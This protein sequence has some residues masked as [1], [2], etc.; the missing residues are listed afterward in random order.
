MWAPVGQS[1]PA[2]NAENTSEKGNLY[3]T[4]AEAVLDGL[5]AGTSYKVKVRARYQDDSGP[6][7]DEVTKE[8]QA[9]A[10]SVGTR[11]DTLGTVS[12]LSADPRAFLV[13][14]TWTAIKNNA[15][16]EYEVPRGSS[17]DELAVIGTATTAVYADGPVEA[18]T[19]YY[20][21]VRARSATGFGPTSDAL[22]VTTT[23]ATV[24][25]EEDEEPL[26]A[27]TQQSSYTLVSNLH[28]STSGSNKTVRNVNATH[29]VRVEQPF[30]TGNHPDGYTITEI[31]AFVKSITGSDIG[32]S[33]HIH[34]DNGKNVSTFDSGSS[35]R[36]HSFTEHTG[37]A[38]DSTVRFTSTD[39]VTLSPNT[40]YWLVFAMSA[41]DITSKYELAAAARGSLEITPCGEPGWSIYAEALDS[42]YEI[43]TTNKTDRGN[44]SF[45]PTLVAVIGNQ[46][47]DASESELDCISIPM[48]QTARG[49]L[50]VD[51]D[52]DLFVVE[53]EAGVD[54]Q[55]DMFTGIDGY[56]ATLSGGHITGIYN[57][58]GVAQ[59]G[60]HLIGVGPRIHHGDPDPDRTQNF[61]LFS[62]H[63]NRRAYFKPASAGTYYLEVG[64]WTRTHDR[65][66]Y[67]TGVG[68][69]NS[70]ATYTVRVREA[71][72]YSD[73][74]MGSGEVE[75]GGSIRGHFFT[76]HASV[77]DFDRI[78]VNLTGGHT[79]HLNLTGHAT[80]NTQ[81]KI[82]GV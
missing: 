81:M 35:Q 64:P 15:I 23:A 56:G 60:V 10:A 48:G 18:E 24:V 13:I 75:V 39:A 5:T 6:W 28:A 57:S 51:G 16:T 42:Q 67:T 32:P 55:F 25:V 45:Q 11:D 27:D 61:D 40:R 7:T 34:A 72:D 53:L 4:D 65:A 17:A 9:A 21:A 41:T 14:L 8:V 54:Y 29:A 43:G 19:T 73:G 2:W 12:D 58:G 50:E 68:G 78:H 31:Q 26:V 71:D 47:G 66:T 49:A 79:Y 63:E 3:P 80:A 20:Y 59:T 52:K 77:V 82:D 37:F 30:H 44:S 36:L 33:V 38:A 22:E 1:Y 69:P 70:D 74:I 62:Y 46:A 76:E